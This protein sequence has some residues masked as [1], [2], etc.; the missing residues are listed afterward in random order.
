MLQPMSFF[1]VWYISSLAFRSPSHLQNISKLPLL[2]LSPTCICLTFE[3]S[4]GFC[5]IHFSSGV[6]TSSLVPPLYFPCPAHDYLFFS[7]FLHFLLKMITVNLLSSSLNA[8]AHYTIQT[9]I[10]T[11]CIF[12]NMKYLSLVYHIK[13]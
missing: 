12:T 5:V 1:H 13:H 4:S 2:T 8:N 10:C 3:K 7:K 9:F 11:P 6:L